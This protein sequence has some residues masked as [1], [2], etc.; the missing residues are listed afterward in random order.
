[1][2]RRTDTDPTDTSDPQ[3]SR[4]RNTRRASGTLV[5]LTMP[6]LLIAAGTLGLAV[7]TAHAKPTPVQKCA[8]AKNKAA[9]KYAA[10]L[11]T[12][13]AAFITSTDAGKH[14]IAR[15]KCRATFLKAWAAADTKAAKAGATCDDAPLTVD[16]FDNAVDTQ[17]AVLGLGL[18]GSGLRRCGDN[19][20]QGS[21]ACD[22]NDFGAETCTTQGFAGGT[23]QCVSGCFVDT[24]G[25]FA[26]RYVDNGDGTVTDHQTGLQ[27][28]QKTTAAGSG[29]NLADPH[30][31][32]NS[33]TW[34]NLAGCPSTGCPNGTVFTDFLRQ[35]N[36][37]TSSDGMVMSVA[38]FA[39]HCDW[40]LP[41]IQELQTIVDVTA[42]GCGTGSSGCIDPIFGPAVAGGYWSA[43]TTTDSPG[44]T[45][46]SGFGNG[47]L[48][49]GFKDDPNGARAVRTGS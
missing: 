3:A 34:G 15:G 17:N 44:L 33:Y 36:G 18:A 21:E 31:V 10:C 9:G 49:N 30:D 16:D 39:G 1:M 40:R 48:L 23:L 13:T 37:C 28:E 29:A 46:N 12:A 11:Q 24:S 4:L 19:T 41:T 14:T 35:L 22:G 20:R 38:G 27:W 7:P 25:C 45:W 42:A 32:D 2:T 8:V 43:T 26:T 5:L 6:V 47:S